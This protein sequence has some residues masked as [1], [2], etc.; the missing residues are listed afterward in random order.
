MSRKTQVTAEKLFFKSNYDFHI[1]II[2]LTC[3]GIKRGKVK[4]KIKKVNIKAAAT[5]CHWF[6][7]WIYLVPY[8]CN[9]RKLGLLSGIFWNPSCSWVVETDIEQSETKGSCDIEKM[10]FSAV[11]NSHL[12]SQSHFRDAYTEAGQA[13]VKDVREHIPELYFKIKTSML[14]FH[15]KIIL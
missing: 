10:L 4:L 2:F 15:L 6:T 11:N 12:Q 8:F 9:R 5:G 13:N 7:T 1:P 14:Y 3:S